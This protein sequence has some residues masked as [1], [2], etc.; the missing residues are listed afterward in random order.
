MS[1]FNSKK[2]E[3]TLK[4]TWRL[5]ETDPEGAHRLEDALHRQLVDGIVNGEFDSYETLREHALKLR[6]LRRANFPRWHG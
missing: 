3:D 2:F 1:L 5:A 4:E 6:E